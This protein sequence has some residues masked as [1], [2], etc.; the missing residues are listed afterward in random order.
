MLTANERMT[1]IHIASELTK[2]E[3]AK[4]S[5]LNAKEFF[6]EFLDLLIARHE[7]MPGDHVERAT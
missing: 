3:M 4:K 7:N 5:L 1:L 6:G 2:Q